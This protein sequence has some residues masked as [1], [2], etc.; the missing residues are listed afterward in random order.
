MEEQERI[1]SFYPLLDS[2][3][4][5]IDQQFAQESC[6]IVSAVGKLLNLEIVKAD[7]EILAN[8]FKV[9][10]DELEAE[11]TLIRDYDGPVSKGCTTNTIKEW[12]D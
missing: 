10:A 4:T 12:L 6:D 2:L 8:K 1:T 5:G 3:R 9:S 11:I 7:M